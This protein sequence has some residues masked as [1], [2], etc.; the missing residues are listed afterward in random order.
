MINPKTFYS[1]VIS[2][3]LNSELP[4]DRSNTSTRR[5][6]IRGLF[7]WA[8]RVGIGPIILIAVGSGKLDQRG[9]C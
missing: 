8:D 9:A 2:S 3:S 1:L 7:G 6:Q 4:I 5:R